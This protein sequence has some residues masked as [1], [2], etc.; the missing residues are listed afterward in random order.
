MLKKRFAEIVMLESILNAANKD[1]QI[2]NKEKT[3][4]MIKETRLLK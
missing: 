1:S 4:D 2:I 3:Y